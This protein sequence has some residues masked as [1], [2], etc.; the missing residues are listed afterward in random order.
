MLLKTHSFNNHPIDQLTQ[1]T[2]ISKF[3]IPAGYV[4]ATQMCKANNKLWGNY[5]Q[6]DNTKAYWKALSTDIG[7]P[8]SELV[9]TIRGG[10]DEQRRSQG[11]WVHPEI[12]IDLAQ[13][14]S[15]EFRIWANRE[16]KRVIE[17]KA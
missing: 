14:V 1:E 5:A 11:T 7:I 12:A 15:V 17:Q 16:L 3:N 4:N 2:R 6:L 8:I 9:L 10:N 13:W